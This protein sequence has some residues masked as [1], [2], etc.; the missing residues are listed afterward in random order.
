V[1]MDTGGTNYERTVLYVRNSGQGVVVKGIT[2]ADSLHNI[3]GR[4][5]ASSQADVGLINNR[6][7]LV[8]FADQLINAEASHA[9][10]V[11]AG[12]NGIST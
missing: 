10:L 6:T 2:T 4:L 12:S 8:A 1:K 9:S 3:G 5:N 7:F 11:S